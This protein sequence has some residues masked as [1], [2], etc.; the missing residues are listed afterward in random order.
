MENKYIVY[1]HTNK[2][3]GKRYVGITGMALKKRWKR[4]SEY[5][6]S[7]H[8][9]NSIQKYGWDGFT[10]YILDDGLTKEEAC[11][12]E[13]EYIAKYKTQDRRYGYN[14]T[15]GGEHCTHNE[16]SRKKNSEAR[17]Q[18]YKEHPDAKEKFARIN[19]GRHGSE[20]QKLAAKKTMTNL[21]AD[22]SFKE[23]M[24]AIHRGAN[25]CNYGGVPD[26]TRKRMRES[27]AKARKCVCVETGVEYPSCTIA[28]ER[29]GGNPSLI[30]QVCAGNRK[31]HQKRHWKFI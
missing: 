28:A 25:N 26:E 17:K 3:N 14:V 11:A 1:V 22:D 9:Y 8:F 15:S 23:K 7:P 21:W 29:T 6:G 4:G 18:Y 31:T 5:K 24:S 2:T 27:S 16:E 12:M 19:V 13:Q 10:H 30:Y 20:I